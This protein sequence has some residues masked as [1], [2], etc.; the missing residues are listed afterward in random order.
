MRALE[1][2]LESAHRKLRVAD[3]QLHAQ[4]DRITELLEGQHLLRWQQERMMAIL[5]VPVLMT[6]LQG[7]VRTVNAA[8]ASLV[9]MQVS[10]LV[11]KT[12]LRVI[13]PQDRGDVERL[14][15]EL[16]GPDESFR[17]AVT[18]VGAPGD[19][20]IDAEIFVSTLP[21]PAPQVVWMLLAGD[22]AGPSA[23]DRSRP[24]PEALARLALLPTMVTGEQ[25]ALTRAAAICQGCL[26]PGT[27]VSVSLGPPD[28]PRV[29][30]ATSQVAQAFDG[31]QLAAGEGPCVTAFSELATVE[32][33][34]PAHDRRW[35]RF[36]ELSP[37]EIQGVVAAPL[38]VGED[39]IGALNVYVSD[40]TWPPRLRQDTELLAAT[41]AAMVF[42]LGL[43]KELEVLAEDMRRALESRATI[44]QAK[45]IVMANRRVD[46]DAAFE[47]LVRL[48]SSRHV[49][50]REVAEE[51]VRRASE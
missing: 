28:E 46:A 41:V 10:Q 18:L 35:P 42:E 32:S 24:L 12:A 6:D 30:A 43:K 21:G 15:A 38:E 9:R 47:H 49:K 45:G 50:L 11:G 37:A 44:D 22:T 48:S 26:G 8:A 2:D 31:A 39:L 7:V 34:D 3:E 1:R 33:T 40:P 51:I 5:P 17:R 23:T 13:S 16:S 25:E 36:G 29:L 14:L 27:A 4:Q 19:R 20:A